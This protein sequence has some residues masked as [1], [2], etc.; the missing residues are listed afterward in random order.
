VADFQ[1]EEKV[2]PEITLGDALRLGSAIVPKP[3]SSEIKR[4]GIGMVYE[5]HGVDSTR[6]STINLLYP[7]IIDTVQECPW[8]GESPLVGAPVIQHPFMLHYLTGEITIEAIAEWLDIISC[9]LSWK[10][11]RERIRAMLEKQ[12]TVAPEALAGVAE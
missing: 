5:A 8:C 6:C 12:E 10:Q 2:M 3:H 7:G 4:C 11:M 9:R 1:Q